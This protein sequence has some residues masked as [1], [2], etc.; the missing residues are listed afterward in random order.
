MST[1]LKDKVVTITGAASGIGL[2]TAKLLAARGAKVS[3]ADISGPQLEEV[4]ANIQKAGGSATFKVVDVRNRKEVEDWIEHTLNHYGQKL[5]GAVNLAGVNPKQATI[6]GIEDIDQDDWDHVLGVNINGTLNCLRA[7]LKIMSP[8]ASIVNASSVWGIRAI[9]KNGAY[10]TS[11]HAV[12][13]LTK[14]ASAEAAEKGV[15]VN[16]IAP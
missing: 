2:A 13:G 9:A 16:A 14:A 10:V 11:K 4:V 12:I 7:Q 1:D 8:H 15:R 3:L 5:D 6:A